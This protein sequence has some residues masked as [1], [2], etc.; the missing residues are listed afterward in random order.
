[1]SLPSSGLRNWQ[2]R[3]ADPEKHWKRGASAFET[4]VSWEL[5]AATPRGLPASVADVLDQAPQLQEA[6]VVFAFPEHQVELDGGRRPSQNDVWAFLRT[7]TGYESLS[8]EAKASEPL[9]PTPSD[10]QLD[11]SEGKQGRLAWLLNELEISQ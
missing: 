9:G 4:A 6:E 2:L 3:L 8:V 1:M 10:W 11:R 7:P 5:A